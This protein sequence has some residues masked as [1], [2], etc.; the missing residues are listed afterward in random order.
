M[1]KRVNEA[2]RIDDKDLPSSDPNPESLP[3]SPPGLT[4]F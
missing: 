1:Q 4:D 2:T 3:A